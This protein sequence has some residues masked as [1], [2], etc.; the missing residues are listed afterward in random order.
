ML[1]QIING[2]GLAIGTGFGSAIGT[3]FSNKLV[4]KHLD[5]IESKIKEKRK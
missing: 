4:I 5:K 1:E 3:Y 2:I